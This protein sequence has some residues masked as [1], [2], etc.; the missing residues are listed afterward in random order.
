LHFM[1]LAVNGVANA[2]LWEAFFAVAPR[3]SFRVWLHCKNRD[4]CQ[5]AAIYK[6]P[7]LQMVPSVQSEWCADLVSAPVSMVRAALAAGAAPPGSMEKFVLLSDSTLPAKPFPKV[8]D[9]LTAQ[10]VSDICLYETSGWASGHV[11]GMVAPYLVEHHQWFVLNRADAKSLVGYWKP[12]DLSAPKPNGKYFQPFTIPI[13]GLHCA[14]GAETATSSAF[15]DLSGC[16]DELAVFATLFGVLDDN[17]QDGVVDVPG[18]G[19]VDMYADTEQGRCRTLVMWAGYG[20]VDRL[21]GSVGNK[22]VNSTNRHPGLIEEL[23][24]E[25]MV[26][27]RESSYLFVRKVRDNASLPHFSE[28]V[29]SHE[30]ALKGRRTG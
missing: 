7:G 13:H 11:G 30:V 20:L 17:Q 6:L 14:D 18:F 12:P 16:P 23:S 24:E 28:L 22:V 1:F 2:H 26:A 10:D 9:A 21:S 29:L 19:K 8:F 27:L 3:E 4:D 15:P 25:A 5:R